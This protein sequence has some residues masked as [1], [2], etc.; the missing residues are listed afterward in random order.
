[1]SLGAEDSK[2]LWSST[3]SNDL[4]TFSKVHNQLLPPPGQL[5]NI[6]L[7]IYLPS[8]NTDDPAKA[9]IKV[10]Q[11]QFPPNIANVMSTTA[12]QLRGAGGGQPQTLGTALNKLLPG[13]FPSRRT[14]ILAKPLLHGATVPMSA[15]LEDLAR[16]CCYADGWVGVVIAMIG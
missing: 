8:S 14:T 4:S 15:T 13:L 6:P 16:R 1:M 5:R 7:R 11:A 10:L 12:S 3:Q 2:A 9:Q